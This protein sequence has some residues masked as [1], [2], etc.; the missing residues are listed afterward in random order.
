VELVVKEDPHLAR[1]A[2]PRPLL[3]MPKCL[4]ELLVNFTALD[5]SDSSNV[6]NSLTP[7]SNKPE[8]Q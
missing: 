4:N 6:K 5:I 1:I 7:C 3:L 2:R 8:V